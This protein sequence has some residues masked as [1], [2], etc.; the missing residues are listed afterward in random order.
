M[1][2]AAAS[3]FSASAR[4]WQQ[5]QHWWPMELATD[6][7]TH[8]RRSTVN[9][10][11]SFRRSSDRLV[12][13]H[14]CTAVSSAHA[15]SIPCTQ[16]S[17][18]ASNFCAAAAGERAREAK[19]RKGTR[20]RERER[21]RER[22]KTAWCR[23]LHRHRRSCGLLAATKA[24]PCHVSDTSLQMESMRL[25]ACQMCC[26]PLDVIP[27]CDRCQ[28]SKASVCVRDCVLPLESH[29]ALHI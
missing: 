19:L 16:P 5:Q 6:T 12:T 21:E 29:H 13:G 23:V 3:E 25:L 24:S 18:C 10:V 11:W 28:K 14:A 27:L 7:L 17:L 22:G 20:E 2:A 4:D 1:H 26:V 9:V 8:A 15:L